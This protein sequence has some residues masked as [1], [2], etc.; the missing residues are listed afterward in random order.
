MFNNFP[1]IAFKTSSP[2]KVHH[3]AFADD[4][5]IFIK[6]KVEALKLFS[7]NMELYQKLFGQKLN[8]EKKILF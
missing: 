1:K 6:G 3:L 5:M 4:M 8:K 7:Q 2:L